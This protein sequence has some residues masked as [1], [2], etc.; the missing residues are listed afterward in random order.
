GPEAPAVRDVPVR[1]GV[2]ALVQ[3]TYVNYLLDRPMRA[4]EFALLGQVAAGVPLREAVPHAGADHL[5]RLCDLI[6]EDFAGLAPGP[7]PPVG[8]AGGVWGPAAAAPRLDAERG[9]LLC[10]ARARLGP[11]DRE[12]LRGLL[13]AGPSWGRLRGLADYHGLAPLLYHHL[14][15]CA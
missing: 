8:A 12:R 7:P 4:R 14:S 9:L 3:H 11:A 2:V 1:S 6:L 10:C 13:R 15:A 5:G